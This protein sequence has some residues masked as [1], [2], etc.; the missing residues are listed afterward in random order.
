MAAYRRGDW[1]EAAR[2]FGAFHQACLAAGRSLQA[3][4]AANNWSVAL[5]QAGRSAESLQAVA[6]TPEV[7]FQAGDQ[8]HTAQAWAN[9]GAALEACGR[10]AEAEQSFAQAIELFRVLGDQDSL[11]LCLQAVSRIQLRRGRPMDALGSMQAGLEGGRRLSPTR[12]L[13]R[14]LLDL[15]A[16]LMGGR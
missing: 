1:Q 15:P 8:R 11:S 10:L 7:F 12:R 5:L 16:R 13:I 3:A 9:L 6:G 4:E 14:R 2:R